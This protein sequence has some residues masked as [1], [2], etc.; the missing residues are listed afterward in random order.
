MK[1]RILLWALRRFWRNA[2]V[3]YNAEIRGPVTISSGDGSLVADCRLETC[4]TV[5]GRE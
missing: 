4:P 2:T 5:T 1:N 3:L